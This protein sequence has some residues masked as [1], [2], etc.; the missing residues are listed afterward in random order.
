M[1]ELEQD[2]IKEGTTQIMKGISENISKFF[3][4][5]GV[6]KEAVSTLIKEINESEEYSP[7]D[8]ALLIA[9]SKKLV[10]QK[11]I[12]T[13]LLPLLTRILLRELISVQIQRLMKNG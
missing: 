10:S 9:N 4:Y 1:N 2:I 5:L 7:I 13:I 6:K 3:P 12:L 8:K 11:K